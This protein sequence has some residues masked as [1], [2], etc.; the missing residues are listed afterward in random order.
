MASELLL[1]NKPMNN[2]CTRD[3]LATKHLLCFFVNG[4]ALAALLLFQWPHAYRNHVCQMRLRFRDLTY[5]VITEIRIR[6]PGRHARRPNHAV[7]GRQYC[8]RFS[9]PLDLPP[10]L[11]FDTDT[12][13]ATMRV[14]VLEKHR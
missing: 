10:I 8:C 2:K 13:R 3:S 6:R 4:N 11:K 1:T 14:E 5:A 7:R 12:P 9:Q